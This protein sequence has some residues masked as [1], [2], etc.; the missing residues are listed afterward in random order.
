MFKL[1]RF[2]NQFLIDDREIYKMVK[3]FSI[4]F[5]LLYLSTRSGTMITR[6]PV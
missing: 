1:I 3:D 6:H 5:N 4:Q 2:I